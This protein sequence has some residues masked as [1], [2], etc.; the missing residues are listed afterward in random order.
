M[1]LLCQVRKKGN[2]VL[3]TSYSPS[4]QFTIKIATVATIYI[5]RSCYTISSPE[6]LQKQGD[7]FFSRSLKNLSMKNTK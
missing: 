4:D 7:L 2:E 6:N 3:K 5:G 1:F